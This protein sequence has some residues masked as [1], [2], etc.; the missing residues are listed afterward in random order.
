MAKWW[1]FGKNETVDEDALFDEYEAEL[2]QRF[3]EAIAHGHPRQ[4][5]LFQIEQESSKLER[6]EET[7]VSKAKLRAYDLLYSEIR[8]RMLANLTDGKNHEMAGQVDDA[9]RCYQ[10]ATA[11]QVP[12]RFPYEHLRVIYN[13]RQQQ[14]LAL[15]VCQ[16]A[17]KNPYLSDRDHAHFKNWLEKLG[18]A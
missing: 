3:D 14:T 6:G 15:Q 13:R 16:D 10:A 2:R 7:A 17:L 18:D 12:T 11:D 8:P 4:Q 5:L 1:P 9:I